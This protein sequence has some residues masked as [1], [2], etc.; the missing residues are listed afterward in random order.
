MTK[1]R[2]EESNLISA[3]RADIKGESDDKSVLF[4]QGSYH[5]FSYLIYS[6]RADIKGESYDKSVFFKSML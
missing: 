4:N 3:L 6:L 1:H 5:M 2:A